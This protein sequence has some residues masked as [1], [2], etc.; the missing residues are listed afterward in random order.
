MW[1]FYGKPPHNDAIL[2]NKD[3]IPGYQYNGQYDYL[4]GLVML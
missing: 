4:F 3:T 1:H 2:A